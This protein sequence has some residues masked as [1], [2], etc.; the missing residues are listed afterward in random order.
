LP[1]KL[2]WYGITGKAIDWIKSYLVDRYQ[3]MEMKNVNS[4]HQ[5]AS[6]WGKI[7]HNITQ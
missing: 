6:K 2:S 5:I 7:K 1:L 3:S 4:S